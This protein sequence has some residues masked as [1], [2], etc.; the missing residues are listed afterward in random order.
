ML[1]NPKWDTKSLPK[2]N[3]IES[4]AKWLESQNPAQTYNYDCVGSCLLAIYYRAC[5]YRDA[6]LGG[7]TMTYRPANGYL[8]TNINL[9]DHFNRI[10]QGKP[11]TYGAALARAKRYL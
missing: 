2:I 9:P 4:L 8:F 10:A 1:F 11:H 3:T 5:G 7:S 6:M